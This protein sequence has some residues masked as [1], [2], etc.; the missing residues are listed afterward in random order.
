MAQFI[1]KIQ[2]QR[3]QATRLGSKSSGLEVQANG[4]NI[5]CTARLNYNGIKERDEIDIYVTAGSGK[6]KD[7]VYLGRFFCE[8]GEFLKVA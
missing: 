4:W 6:D 1:G 8:D 3:G 5:G 7:R 2:G